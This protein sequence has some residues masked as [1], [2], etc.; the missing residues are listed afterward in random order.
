MSTEVIEHTFEVEAPAHLRISN[1][2]GHVDIQP[3]DEGTIR[4]TALKHSGSG[5]NG[6]TQ[7]IVKQE[8]DGLVVAEAKYENNISNSLEVSGASLPFFFFAAYSI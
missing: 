3:G 6:N 2:R 8:S 5:N 1:V 4:V 7:I